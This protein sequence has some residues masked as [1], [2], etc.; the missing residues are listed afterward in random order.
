LSKFTHQYSFNI[1]GCI[2]A[3]FL[4]LCLRVILITNVEEWSVQ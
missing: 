2:S 1:I 4:C 3:M